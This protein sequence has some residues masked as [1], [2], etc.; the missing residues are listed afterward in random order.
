MRRSATSRA[1]PPSL[2]GARRGAP[3]AGTPHRCSTQ[4]AAAIC[5]GR[6]TGAKGRGAGVVQCATAAAAR[7]AGPHQS[8]GG[9]A[10]P[11]RPHSTPRTQPISRSSTRSTSR[12]GGRVIM[13]RSGPRRRSTDPIEDMAPPIMQYPR[14]PRTASSSGAGL[15][16]PRC[17]APAARASST[18]LRV[19]FW[20]LGSIR[21]HPEATATGANSVPGVSFGAQTFADPPGDFTHPLAAALRAE[22]LGYGKIAG[23][24]PLR[25]APERPDDLKLRTCDGLFDHIRLRPLVLGLDL[26]DLADQRR[27][28]AGTPRGGGPRPTVASPHLRGHRELVGGLPTVAT[29]GL[30]TSPLHRRLNTS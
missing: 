17:V 20:L 2:I 9:R 27:A 26:H 22:A 19:G 3:I 15:S 18:V 11:R 13:S 4:P 14:A 16:C 24:L 30:A 28:E 8:R 23:A 21:E 7:W 5:A 12:P 29:P 6:L 10:V 25:N 1:R